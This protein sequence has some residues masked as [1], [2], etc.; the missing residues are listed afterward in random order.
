MTTK[1]ADEVVLV[2]SSDLHVDNTD[3]DTIDGYHG[4]AGLRA[5]LATARAVAADVVLLA[6][7]TF[8]N[9]RVAQPVLRRTAA[10]LG[11]APLPIV[12]LP[13]NHDS[14]LPDCMFARGG[15]DA[16]PNLHLL[17]V[18]HP[19]TILFPAHD[20]T[21][22]GRAHRGD[23]DIPPLHAPPRTTRW[24]VVI[25]HGHYVPPEDWKAES[26]R[27]WRISDDALAATDA[28]YVAL[29]HWDRAV[30]V[31]DGSVPAYYSGAPHLAGT[32]NVVRLNRRT[33]VMVARVPL[34]AGP[35]S[36]SV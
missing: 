35:A 6:G 15:L 20:L 19:E 25:A 33:G 16:V 14:I 28:D 29:G 7:D 10:L 9:H 12:L 1:D 22:C 31:G 21:V 36:D 5:V 8:E 30:Q 26:H 11:E 18:T 3:P 24:Q 17:G 32:V 4:V 27:A 13:G 2:H 23:D 34:H